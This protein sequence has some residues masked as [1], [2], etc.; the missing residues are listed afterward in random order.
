MATHP[1]P[2]KERPPQ[3]AQPRKL[4]R[5]D[6]APPKLSFDI[7]RNKPKPREWVPDGDAEPSFFLF[8]QRPA[9]EKLVEIPHENGTIL[10]LFLDSD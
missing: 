1:P 8:D 10:I 7:F 6:N 3:P 2:T 5:R 9:S 4:S